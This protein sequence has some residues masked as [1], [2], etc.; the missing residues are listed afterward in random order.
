MS[1]IYFSILR[2]SPFPKIIWLFESFVHPW[3]EL[4]T[5]I[6]VDYSVYATNYCSAILTRLSN[7]SISSVLLGL[8]R[9]FRS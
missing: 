7:A 4:Y 5:N 1:Y 2:S 9:G 6:T 3:D 8:Y